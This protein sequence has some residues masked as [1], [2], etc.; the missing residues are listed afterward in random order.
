[1]N[2][3][4]N[5]PWNCRR[6]SQSIQRNTKQTIVDKN[7]N[8]ISKGKIG[9]EI[10]QKK[11]RTKTLKKLLMELPKVFPN[12]FEKNYEKNC[13]ESCQ[14]KFWT[15]IWKKSNNNAK[16][17]FKWDVWRIPNRSR[18]LEIADGFCRQSLWNCLKPTERFHRRIAYV[19]KIKNI[20]LINS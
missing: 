14:R 2:W 11:G 12:K 4:I 17:I 16:G 10:L 7:A 20:Q 8:K 6:I 1:M 13:Q 3:Q 15:N 18:T 19:K 9:Q 5:V